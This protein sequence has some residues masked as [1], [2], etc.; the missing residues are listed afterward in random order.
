VWPVVCFCCA[1]WGLLDL[2]HCAY[3]LTGLFGWVGVGGFGDDL[4]YGMGE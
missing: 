4:G 1:Y 2:T 3:V